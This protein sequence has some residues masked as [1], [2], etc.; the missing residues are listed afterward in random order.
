MLYLLDAN[1]LM[2]AHNLYYP[3]DA[4]PEFWDWLQF[5]CELGLVKM[6]IE[7]FEEVKD[8]T[9]DAQRDLLYAWVQRAEVRATLLLNGDVDPEH[10]RTVLH[11]YAPDLSD[12]EIE[13]IG[14]DP[15]LIAHALAQPQDRCVVTTEVTNRKKQRQ[16]KKIPDIC[17]DV[18]VL[19][20]DTFAMLR[21]LRFS[22][23]WR[24]KILG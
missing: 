14:R 18:G 16:N 11:H 22:T 4:V 21:A 2:T 20:C 9:T 3:V 19:C 23:N 12:D 24:E 6:P 1:V 8:G 7:T 10:V 17:T 5:Q 13:A 15:F